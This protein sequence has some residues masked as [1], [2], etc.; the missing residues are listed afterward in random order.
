MVVP[1][2][3]PTYPI[4]HAQILSRSYIAFRDSLRNLTLRLQELNGLQ[5]DAGWHVGADEVVALMGA[6][7]IMMTHGCTTTADM[8]VNGTVADLGDR[9]CGGAGGRQRMFTW[10]NS[11]FQVH[12]P[13]NILSFTRHSLGF[14]ALC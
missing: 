1:H 4:K 7:A 3:W 13:C 11:F 6:H 12:L 2:I 8:D 9:T 10:D 5:P 14:V